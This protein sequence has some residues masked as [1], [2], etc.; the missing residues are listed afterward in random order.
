MHQST[1]TI[2]ALAF[3]IWPACSRSYCADPIRLEPIAEVAGTVQ[4]MLARGKNAT[5][6]LLA[7]QNPGADCGHGTPA[8][9]WKAVL[10]PATRNVLRLEK[11]QDLAD[12]QNVRDTL[13]EASDGTLFAGGGWC[14]YKPPYFSSDGGETWQPADAGPVHPPNSTFSFVEFRGSIYAG[15]GY[16]PHHGQVYRWLGEGN[17]TR[18]LDIPPPRSIV[19]NLVVFEEQLFVGS[20]IYGWGGKG[21]ETSVPV[22]VSAD[23]EQFKPT[24]GIPPGFTVSQLLRADD[25][26]V[27][28]ANDQVFVWKER[29][30]EKLGDLAPGIAM[31]RQAVV[32]GRGTIVNHG[33]LP[34]DDAEGLY[35]SNNLGCGWK[36]V[37][38]LQG[39]TALHAH[40]DPLFVSARPKGKDASQVYRVRLDGDISTI[41]TRPWVTGSPAP[42]PN[43]APGLSATVRVELTDGSKVTGQLDQGELVIKTEYGTLRVP[44]DRLRRIER[45]GDDGKP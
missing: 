31:N 16:E 37:E 10:D 11:K 6:L 2:V 29:R 15:T 4:A 21:S 1:K 5:E 39:I 9:V 24:E 44:V 38:V 8:S 14:G 17:W 18:V 33:K 41:A 20:V 34:A 45:V 35:V 25:R 13:V 42:A 30:W 12:I 36:Q 19:N 27:A 26:L 7:T 28:W 3:C 23:G 43:P 22:Y 32:V 40:G